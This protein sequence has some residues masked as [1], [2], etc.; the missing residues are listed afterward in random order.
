MSVMSGSCRS[1]GYHI[2]L[3]AP[4]TCPVRTTTDE[5]SGGRGVAGLSL[6]AS[7]LLSKVFARI[8]PTLN[9]SMHVYSL[10]EGD[11]YHTLWCD[12]RKDKVH[13]FVYLWN[14]T[15]PI[16]MPSFPPALI[17]TREDQR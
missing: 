1:K 16:Y 7:L 13:P 3:L 5:G 4:F 8:S 14:T 12:H 11:V 15:G 9:V 2:D 6:S 10:K 17:H